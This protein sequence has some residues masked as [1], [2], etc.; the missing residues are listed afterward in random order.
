MLSEIQELRTVALLGRLCSSL[1]HHESQSQAQLLQIKS[2]LQGITEC[3][4][5]LHRLV[6]LSDFRT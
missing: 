1:L 6:N 3:T 2:V 4:H 5:S